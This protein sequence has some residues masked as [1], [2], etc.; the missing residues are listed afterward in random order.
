M[1]TLDTV[2][3]G[4]KDILELVNSDK[5]LI[6]EI[7]YYKKKADLGNIDLIKQEAEKN[8]INVREITLN[9]FKILRGTIHSQG[10]FA[11]LN[12]PEHNLEDVISKSK[13]VI[14][15]DNIQDPGNLGTIIRTA[16]VL[17]VDSILLS[18][19]SVSVSN[20]KVLRSIKGYLENIK[21]IEN[22]YLEN[23]IS[24][25]LKYKYNIYLADMNGENIYKEEILKPACFFFGSEGQGLSSVLKN[26]GKK[27]AIP[28]VDN[29]F[30]LNVGISA[31]IIISEVKRKWMCEKK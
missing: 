26:Y 24:L 27:I 3:E 16:K 23:A 21:I 19:G 30:S 29:K 13:L 14:V 22:V 2:I 5:F 11:I 25:F 1:K 4:Y 8:S 12:L 7:L 10:I 6:K 15:F 17:G 31:G 18:K 9:E 20:P 28:M